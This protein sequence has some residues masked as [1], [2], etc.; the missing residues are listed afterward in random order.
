MQFHAGPRGAFSMA[1]KAVELI[2]YFDGSR[3]EDPSG[4][5][6]TYK[7]TS[8]GA[9]AMSRPAHLFFFFRKINLS[10]FRLFVDLGSGDGI[11]A[12][13]AGLF[14]RAIG[15]ESDPDLASAAAG[16]ARDLKIEGRVG[17]IRADF[18]TQ[19]I[20]AADCLYIYPDKPIHALEDL[21]D[22][23][24]GT[25]LV[26]GPHFPPRRL[27]TAAKLKCG[28]ETLAVYRGGQCG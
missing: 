16:A 18:F 14:T 7:L 17:F 5:R 9:W 21:L 22:G 23:W 27:Q 6:L 13:V 12:C 20:W 24:G 28:K 19:R 10:T 8:S 11:A 15:I 4:E 1:G 3:L 25:L 2:R 26:Y